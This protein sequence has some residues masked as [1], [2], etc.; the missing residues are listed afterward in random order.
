[1]TEIVKGVLNGGWS[2]VAGWIAPSVVNV[3]IF[4][5]FV[6]PPADDNDVVDRV[7]TTDFELK[8]ALFVL[9]AAIV[10]L[11]LNAVQTPLYR[12]LEGY[13]W[14]SR[15]RS[16]GVGQQLRDK[17]KLDQD[18]ELA[19]YLS[20]DPSQLSEERWRHLEQ[21]LANAGRKG[22]S[23][24]QWEG[25]L[26]LERLQRYP[27]KDD[28]VLPTRLGNA[29]RRFELY[30]DERYQLDSQSFW[31]QLRGLAPEEMRKQED[32]ARAGVDFFVAFFYGNA[33][34]MLG[35][36]GLFLQSR[37]LATTVLV[38]AAMA[39]SM[40]MSYHLAVRATDEWAAAVEAMVDVGRKPLADG[41]GLKLPA[42]LAEERDMWR[43][44]SRFV[45]DRYSAA[46]FPDEHRAFVE[47]AG[48]D[49][50]IAEVAP[51]P[52]ARSTE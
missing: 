30:A 5:L 46:S 10:G 26:I 3:L 52:G 2:L 48:P 35:T 51:S 12:F 28:N 15:A 50:S 22:S 31:Y 1:M 14:P 13:A 29:I 34:L 16:W 8:V 40:F 27:R 23:V 25:A 47:R 38:L 18:Y 39:V 17:Q 7:L 37:D 36:V 49:E 41:M 43:K 11:I 33:L 20:Y 19:A 42:T 32:A 21:L 45:T 6:L 9:C 44:L 4:A 24:R